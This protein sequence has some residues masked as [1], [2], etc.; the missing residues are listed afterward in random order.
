[1][2]II[3]AKKL[4]FLQG[5]IIALKLFDGKY[6]NLR[7]ISAVLVLTDLQRPV[8]A[9]V[10]N[11]LLNRV[12]VI[13]DLQEPWLG[14]TPRMRWCLYFYQIGYI[15]VRTIGNYAIWAFVQKFSMWCMK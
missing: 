6:F 3:P 13:P 10:T 14:P 9:P 11:W 1:M 15:R 12:L 7:E 2:E 5:Q 4:T 8:A